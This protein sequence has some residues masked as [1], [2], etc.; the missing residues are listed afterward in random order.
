MSLDNISLPKSKIKHISKL[1]YGKYPYKIQVDIDRSKIEIYKK[2]SRTYRT[3]Y[4]NTNFR[5]LIR[6]LKTEVL[7]LFADR[8]G[9]FMLRGETHLSI[10]TV[11][12]DIVTTLVEKYNDRVSIL[13]RPV[14]DQHMNIIFAHRK[15]V[16][17][18]SFFEKYYRFKVYLKNSYELRNSRY[19]SVKEYLKNVESG[20]YRLNTSMYY[21]IHTMIKAHSIGWTS[22]VYLRDADDLMMFQLRFNDDIEKIEEAVLLS[23]LQ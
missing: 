20:N 8:S 10:F 21:F 9:D 3:Y 19:E 16:V 14:S 22:A 15:V 7:D 23:S 18:Q 4:D 17:R 1:Y 6:Q 11:S 13:E 5:Q 12:E 2:N